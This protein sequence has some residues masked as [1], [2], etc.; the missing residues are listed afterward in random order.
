MEKIL[1]DKR[2]VEKILLDNIWSHIKV[3]L[4]VYDSVADKEYPIYLLYEI[5][6]M[7]NFEGYL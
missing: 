6:T 1:L 5:A 4:S 3:S 7:V 2:L